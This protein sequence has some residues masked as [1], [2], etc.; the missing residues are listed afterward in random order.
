MSKKKLS[1]LIREGVAMSGPCVGV[2]W[3]T[4]NDGNILTCSLGAAMLA[5]AGGGL[6]PDTAGITDANREIFKITGLQLGKIKV[7]GNT[8]SYA[9]TTMN[10]S[11]VPRSKVA[12]WVQALGY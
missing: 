4:D 8:L 12:N 11:G 9:I 6:L 3:D 7:G 10:D 1:T 5:T 2:L